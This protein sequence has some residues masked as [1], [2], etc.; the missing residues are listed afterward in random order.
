M[1]TQTFDKFSALVKDHG[2]RFYGKYAGQ[3]EVPME[4][5]PEST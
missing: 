5:G 4:S 2:I 1:A 3:D